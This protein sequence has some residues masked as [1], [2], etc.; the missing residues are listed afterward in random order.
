M[1]LSDANTN[2]AR[3]RAN[4]TLLPKRNV[5]RVWRVR[6]TAS[7][8]S[9]QINEDE[10]SWQG[11][12]IDRDAERALEFFKGFG[13]ANKAV[14]SDDPDIV[15]EA[16]KERRIIV[17]SNRRDFLHH[18]EDFQRRSNFDDC[19]DLWGLVVLPNLHFDREK[20]LAAIKY[21]LEVR[22][23]GTLRWPGIG[24]LNLY[25]RLTKEG[26]LEIRCFKRCPFCENLKNGVA[27]EKP[28]DDWYSSLEKVRR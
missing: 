1:G 17:T 5:S 3:V 10:V 16:W 9:F 18:I 8:K 22:R 24:C 6:K 13:R 7:R 25:I 12:L 14:A 19:R 2:P 23:G 15:A 27:I 4:E 11:F 28:W 20:G 21:G 26:D